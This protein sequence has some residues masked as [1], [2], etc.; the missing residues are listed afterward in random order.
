MVD[1]CARAG[2]DRETLSAH[3]TPQRSH[4]HPL[5]ELSGQAGCGEARA[6]GRCGPL[7][8]VIGGNSQP[9]EKDKCNF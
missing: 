2:E 5:R 9:G 1:L 4:T 8:H 3:S 7:Y 6:A